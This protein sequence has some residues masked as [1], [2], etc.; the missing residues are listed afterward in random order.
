M[1][2]VRYLV[3]QLDLD[4]PG[5]EDESIILLDNATYHRG[6]EIKNYFQ[7]MQIPIMYSAPYSFSTAPIET[8]FANLKLGEINPNN[9]STG[10]K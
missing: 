1:L 4:S 10:K 7:K 9:D 5:W 8:L 2:F 3:R 6:E